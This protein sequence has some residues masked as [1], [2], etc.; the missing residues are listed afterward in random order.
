MKNKVV[1]II[2]YF[3]K[4]PNYFTLWLK[5]AEKNPEFDFLIYSDLPLRLRE[6]SNVRQINITFD[7]VRTKI[8]EKI[9][10]KICLQTPYKLC[11]YKPAY[12]Y[13]F[14]NEI[15]EYDFWG[16]MDIDLILG[17]I[18]DYVT[19]DLLDKYD[20]LFFEGH[21]SLF[22]NCTLMNQLFFRC[23]PRVLNWK[24]A[25]TTKYSCHFDENGTVAWAHEVDAKSGIRFYTAWNFMDVPVSSYEIGNGKTEGFAIWDDGVLNYYSFDGEKNIELMYIHLQKREMKG[26][27]LNDSKRFAIAR[28][29][30]YD[31]EKKYTDEYLTRDMD[32]KNKADFMHTIAKKR[33][34][35]KIRNLKN[36]ALKARICRLLLRWKSR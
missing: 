10:G 8:Q 4:I 3:G 1:F 14:F 32:A 15:A 12:G 2:P 7:A 13:V 24:Y 30:F 22:R 35:E 36:G 16:F 23:Y 19:D 20:K 18:S 25:F 6:H 29:S 28:N 27:V 5:S 26:D 9:P 17:K 33:R 11:D 21:F 31:L 34:Q